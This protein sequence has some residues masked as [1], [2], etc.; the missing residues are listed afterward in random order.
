MVPVD[1]MM[2]V[3]SITGVPT[4]G[5]RFMGTNTEGKIYLNSNVRVNPDSA[6]SK[7]I[8]WSLPAGSPA[9]TVIKEASL[10]SPLILTSSMEGKISVTA[11]IKNGLIHK[12]YTETF[13]IMIYPIYTVLLDK[14]GGGGGIDSIFG[15]VVDEPMTAGVAPP[16]RNGYTFDG[17]W[18]YPN[19]QGLQYYDYGMQSVRNFS[20]PPTATVTL[21]AKWVSGK[22]TITGEPPSIETLTP[23]FDKTWNWK[24]WRWDTVWMFGTHINNIGSPVMDGWGIAIDTKTGPSAE[25]KTVH[26]RTASA[27]N[28]RTDVNY[29]VSMDAAD[30]KEGVTYYVRSYI[31]CRDRDGVEMIIYGNEVQ[32]KGVKEPFNIFGPIF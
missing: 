10:K 20:R 27:E 12:D 8:L 9:T 21:Y 16:S 15:L 3:S 28:M 25:F 32:F 4:S 31:K 19:G 29:P 1:I 17:Y 30:F 7:D 26:Y 6:Q 22:I 24:T 23:F 11:T 13:E 5:T 14:Q 2:P 18:E